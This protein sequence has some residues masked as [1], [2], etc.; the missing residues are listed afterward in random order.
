ML[1]KVFRRSRS[2]R[3]RPSGGYPTGPLALV[4]EV[5]LTLRVAFVKRL[6]QAAEAAGQDYSRSPSVPSHG[7]HG[8]RV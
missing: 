3:L 8:E 7:S 4:D 2:S 5:S 6:G 1:E